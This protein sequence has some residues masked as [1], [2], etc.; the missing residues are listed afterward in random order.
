LDSSCS[1]EE[2]NNSEHLLN[3]YRKGKRLEVDPEKDMLSL[4]FENRREV[5]HDMDRWREIVVA[6]KTI[7]E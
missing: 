7:K 2:M 5:T 3:G 4:R 6:A 1:E